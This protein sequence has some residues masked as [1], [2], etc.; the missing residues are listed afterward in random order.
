MSLSWLQFYI[1]ISMSRRQSCAIESAAR[2]YPKHDVYVLFASPVGYRSRTALDLPKSIEVLKKYPNIHLRN[3]N[4]W[5]YAKST[6]LEVWLSDGT[7]SETAFWI[8]HIPDVLRYLTLYNFGGIYLDAVAQRN[9]DY[10][11]Q[12]TAGDNADDGCGVLQFDSDQ[13]L[14][15]E[16]LR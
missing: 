11:E 10:D 16:C 6:P 2:L 4:L 8:E 5:K 3:N 13:S 7:L 14:G 9:F 1:C 12:S 15:E